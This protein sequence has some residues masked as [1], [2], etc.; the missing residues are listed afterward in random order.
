MQ[1]GSLTKYANRYENRDVYL[2]YTF[3][4]K[5][6]NAEESQLVKARD[7]SFEIDETIVRIAPN[8][9]MFIANQ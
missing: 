6:R 4:R 5:W 8:A 7:T 3:E 9:P 2:S 1:L